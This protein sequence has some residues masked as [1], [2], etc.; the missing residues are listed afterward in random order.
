MEFAEAQKEALECTRCGLCQSRT[1]VVFGEG[2]LNARL[3]VVGEAPGHNEDAAGRPFQGAS[4]MLLEGL[5]GSVGLSREEVYLTTLV[6]CRPP[7][8]PP[9]SPR[10]S[11]V[12]SCRR[13]LI[14]QLV[15]V[16]PKVVVALGE[17]PSKILTGRKESLRRI[18]GRAIPLDGRYVIPTFSLQRALYVPADR[19]LLISD[20]SRLPELLEAERPATYETLNVPSQTA[21]REPLQPGL[22]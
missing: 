17:L 20:F 2:P 21:E 14:S 22:W 11:E 10:P 18:R 1:R 13:Y 9:R 12:S 8:T 7:G 19:A 6:K 4:G 16:D 15:A 5:L 3:F